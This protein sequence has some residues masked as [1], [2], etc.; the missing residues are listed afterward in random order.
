MVSKRI[1]TYHEEQVVSTN[2]WQKSG[3]SPASHEQ[4]RS[5]QQSLAC[6][7]PAATCL[8]GQL[9]PLCAQMQP[10]HLQMVRMQ[11]PSH[12]PEAKDA[13]VTKQ[14]VWL[15][16]WHMYKGLWAHHIVTQRAM[17][18]QGPFALPS[19]GGLPPAAMCAPL[20]NYVPQHPLLHLMLS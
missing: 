10:Q 16:D 3:T 15:A 6:S 7:L 14:D 20:L 17:G 8:H 1:H 2:T 11:H 12:E 19:P 18:Q 9:Q 13:A 4:L 5:N